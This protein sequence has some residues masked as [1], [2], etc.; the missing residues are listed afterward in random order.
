MA[1]ILK[2]KC[3]RCGQRIAVQPRHLNKL[4][5][6]PEC[7]EA[8][9]PLAEQIVSARAQEGTSAPAARGGKKRGKTAP[10]TE[11]A[12]GRPCANCG[13]TIGRL[14][15]QHTWEDKVVCK[16]CHRKLSNEST[17]AGAPA[18]TQETGPAK[19]ARTSR[20][21]SKKSVTKVTATVAAP[22]AA[23]ALL[24]SD[25]PAREGGPL[26]LNLA[27]HTLIGG[28]ENLR[29]I[30]MTLG[31]T[32]A[33]LRGRLLAVLVVV[34][35]LAA[36]VYGAMSLL[37]DIAGLIASVAFVMLAAVATWLLLRAGLQAGRRFIAA[38]MKA[39]ASPAGAGAGEPGAPAAV[40][41]AKALPHQE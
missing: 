11:E 37:R 26:A 6:C 17:R 14:Q 33:T 7:G 12:G 13:D 32:W 20:W 16:T 28:V 3:E 5:T 39:A 31:T 19:K 1:G 22:V 41:L 34:C 2:F 18:I 30:P 10:E 9:H 27:P 8:T 35:I 15:K 24:P 4:I 25:A 23:R 38:R 36:A 29:V 21:R 40:E